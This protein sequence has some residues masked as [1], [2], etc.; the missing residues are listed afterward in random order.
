MTIALRPSFAAATLVLTATIANAAG[1]PAPIAFAPNVPPPITRSGN[2]GASAGSC[3]QPQSRQI[4]KSALP[5]YQQKY[6]V[7]STRLCGG[8]PVIHVFADGQPEAG[9]EAVDPGLEDV[10]FHKLREQSAPSRAA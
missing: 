6:N 4:Q 9:F 7:L 2:S 3:S 10:Y 8:E 5:E 1:L